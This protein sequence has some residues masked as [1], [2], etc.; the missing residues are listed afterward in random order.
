MSVVSIGIGQENTNKSVSSVNA[1]SAAPANSSATNVAQRGLDNRA[2]SKASLSSKEVTVLETALGVLK[3]IGKWIWDHKLTIAI[4]VG[5]IALNVLFPGGALVIMGIVVTVM[6]LVANTMFDGYKDF[7]EN[8]V[9]LLPAVAKGF[10][11]TIDWVLKNAATVLLALAN[12]RTSTN[13]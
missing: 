3:D 4:L 8:M 10:N 5:F 7:F 13:N 11:D 12:S 1:A 9:P 2:P 6:H